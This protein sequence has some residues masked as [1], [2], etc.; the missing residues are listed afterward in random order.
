MLTVVFVLSGIY[1]G[2]NLGARVD[3][4]VGD[5]IGAIAGGVAAYYLRKK[6]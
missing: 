2:Q 1:V 5:V 3:A 4:E 6:L